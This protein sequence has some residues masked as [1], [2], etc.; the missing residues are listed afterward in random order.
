MTGTGRAPTLNVAAKAASGVT[1]LRAEGVLD[2]DSYI[3]LRDKIIDAA[4]EE[5]RVVIVDITEL[6]VPAD[7]ALSAFSSARW[8]ANRWPEVPI[9]LVCGHADLRDAVARSGI[10]ARVPVYPTIDAAL[11]GLPLETSQWKRRRARADLPAALESLRRSRELTTEWLTVWSKSDLIPVT[12]VVVTALV[13]NVLRHTDSRPQVRLETDGAT[14]TVA[15]GD[16]SHT[17]AAVREGNWAHNAPSGLLIVAALCR[18]WGNAPT[19]G[20]K[21]V[22]ALIGPENRL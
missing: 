21:T 17:P 12:K 18:S 1:V 20:G 5:P 11:D 7:S 14:V 6:Q 19:P 4:L 16:S 2:T 9:V 15:V 3:A 22:W 10:A 8:I 13:E